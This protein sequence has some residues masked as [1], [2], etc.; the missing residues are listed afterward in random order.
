MLGLLGTA[1]G[2]GIGLAIGAPIAMAP[3]THD[4]TVPPVL[5]LPWPMAAAL[6]LIVPLVA[7][8]V[9]AICVP[10]RPVLVRRTA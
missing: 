10:A 7:A 4:D 2:T 3:T 5:G 1:L 8:L 9:A 6:V